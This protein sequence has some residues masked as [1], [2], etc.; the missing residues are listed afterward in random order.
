MKRLRGA[1]ANWQAAGCN[2]GVA[3]G[4]CAAVDIKHKQVHE[5]GVWPCMQHGFFLLLLLRRLDLSS[6]RPWARIIQLLLHHSK[7]SQ[8]RCLKSLFRLRQIYLDVFLIP[9]AIKNLYTDYV[10]FYWP[11]KA[12]GALWLDGRQSFPLVKSGRVSLCDK[13][14]PPLPTKWGLNSQRC[15]RLRASDVK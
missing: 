13:E 1:Q 8:W 15:G 14:R 7:G 4:R 3:V 6:L 12:S 11:S 2:E 10:S 9:P 5:I